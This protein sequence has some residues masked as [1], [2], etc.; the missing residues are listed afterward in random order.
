MR[1]NFYPSG[2]LANMGFFDDIGNGITSGFHSVTDFVGHTGG[3][4]YDEVKNIANGAIKLGTP[5]VNR[6][7]DIV[8]KV[9]DR[10]INLADR[11]ANKGLDQVDKVGSLLTNPLVIIGALV[12]AVIVV[13]PILA[14]L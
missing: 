3:S 12:A 9:A 2:I 13:P 5:V 1:L 4:I 6:L 14:K 8:D 11:V 7:G 10:G